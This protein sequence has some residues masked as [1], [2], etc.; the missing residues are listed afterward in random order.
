MAQLESK[1]AT[2]ENRNDVTEAVDKFIA[3]IGGFG[4][5][6]VEEAEKLA[7]KDSMRCRWL[8]AIQFWDLLNLISLQML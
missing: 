3:V 1:Q 4:E 5:T 2:K 8:T 6:T 7:C